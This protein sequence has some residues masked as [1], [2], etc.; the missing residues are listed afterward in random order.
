VPILL[1]ISFVFIDLDAR[2]NV[3]KFVV[4]LAISFIYYFRFSFI[5]KWLEGFRRIFLITPFI[6]FIL[7]FFGVFNIFKMD[8]YIG[9][10]QTNTIVDGEKTQVS[11]TTDTRTFL[12]EE[13]LYSAVKNNYI[14]FGRTPA[15]GNESDFFGDDINQDLKTGRKERNDNEVAILNI[16]NWT[17]ALGVLLYFILFYWASYLSINKS[18]N[19]FIKMI[20]LY[21]SFRWI[22]GWVEDFHRFDLST[23]YLWFMIC[24][25]MSGTFRNMTNSEMK[26]WVYGIFNKR[27]RVIEKIRDLK[28][29]EWK[30][31]S[32]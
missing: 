18:K 25:C 3:I 4:P 2:S 24:M 17:G 7:A 12:Y 22:Y 6:L 16:F 23:I 27:Y 30:R 10:L 26:I 8:E 11:L 29:E 13:V 5:V 20:G 21:V 14:I 1:T 19:I 31:L 9:D 15:R 32:E 28:K